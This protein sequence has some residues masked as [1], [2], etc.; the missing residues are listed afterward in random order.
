MVVIVPALAKGQ[1][2]HPPAVGG[3]V[4]GGV[5]SIAIRMGRAIDE[6]GGMEHACDSQESTPNEPRHTTDL[7]ENNEQQQ[8]ERKKLLVQEP[9]VRIS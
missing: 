7:I 5:G 3:T 6:P 8:A 2:S 4:S 1:Q 9:I